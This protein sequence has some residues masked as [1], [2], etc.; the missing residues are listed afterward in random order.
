MVRTQIYLTQPE[1]QGLA[2]LAKSTGKTFS[3]LIREA[4]NH[5]L[6]QSSGS[7][8]DTVLKA[9]AGLWKD[10]EDIPDF[11]DIRASWERGRQ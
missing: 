3:E 4:V 9:T 5:L 2:E 7:R 10:R 11:C 8:K 6:E 1:R